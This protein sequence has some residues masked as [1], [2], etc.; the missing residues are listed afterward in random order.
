MQNQSSIVFVPTRKHARLTAMDILGYASADGLPKRFLAVRKL[1]ATR[2]L[3]LGMACMRPACLCVLHLQLLCNGVVQAAVLTFGA[4][5]AQL[6][7]MVCLRT[8]ATRRGVRPADL[9]NQQ[10]QQL[11]MKP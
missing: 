9:V 7:V 10:Y 8:Y 3:Q 4:A 5:R 2:D 1:L 11:R 6:V